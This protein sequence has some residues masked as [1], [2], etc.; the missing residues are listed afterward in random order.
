MNERVQR[1]VTIVLDD[2]VGELAD[3][4]IATVN[5]RIAPAK[6]SLTALVNEALR[7]YASKPAPAP[8]RDPE[9]ATV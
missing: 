8:Q 9:P 4:Y 1:K 6:L 2:G 5:A 7:Q 3:E